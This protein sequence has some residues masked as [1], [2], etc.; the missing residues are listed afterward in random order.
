[1]DLGLTGR[2]AFVAASTSGLGRASAERLAEAGAVVAI[3]GRG[4]ERV[5]EVASAIDG[6]VAVPGDLTD[7]AERAQVIAAVREQLGE[8]D[9][10]V[11]N[12]PGPAPG[13]AATFTADQ[14][15]ESAEKLLA[16]HVDLVQAFLPGMRERGWG[17]IVLI[18]S[19]AVQAPLG[20][21]V[22]SSAGR[23]AAAAYLKTLANEVAGEGITVNS[24][25][26]GR[27]RTP[28]IEQLDAEAAERT[29]R[30]V[31]DVLAAN[32]ANIPAG[33]LGEPREFGACVAFL[34]SE[35][36]AYVTGVGLRVDGGMVPVL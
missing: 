22:G 36:A 1:M 29:G 35:P 20:N 25:L 33:R 30:P 18:G 10:L 5:D 34:C 7:A 27:I 23:S 12:G 14:A 21:L 28:R 26:P 4:A 3:N 6:A 31:E 8:V 2:K 19:T 17:R 24:V 16:P 13:S 11:L 15:R 9:I 32:L